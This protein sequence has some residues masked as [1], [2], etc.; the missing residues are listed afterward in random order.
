[1]A[2][3]NNIFKA[4]RCLKL[5]TPKARPTNNMRESATTTTSAHRFRDV[6]Q[7][8]DADHDGRISGVELDTYFEVVGNGKAAMD[9][10]NDAAGFLDYGEF[11]RLMEGTRDDDLRD[12]FEVFEHERGFGRITPEGLCRALDRLG[13][14]RTHE[15]CVSMIQAY[16]VNGDGTLD[17]EEFKRMMA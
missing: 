5:K 14:V 12:A 9:D 17:F 3:T 6:F 1:M 4:L 2:N 13:D 16:D 8:L 7:Y 15:E 11:E 10:D